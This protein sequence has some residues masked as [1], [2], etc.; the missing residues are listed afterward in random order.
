MG[1]DIRKND[2]GEY[3]IISSTSDEKI[4]DDEWVSEDEAKRILI[5]RRLANFIK[6]II[7]IDMEFPNGYY[8]NDKLETNHIDESFDKWY[9]NSLMCDNHIEQMSEKATEIRDRLDLDFDII[10][11]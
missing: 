11:R 8:I 10:E 7:E 4:H 5:R 1:L 6:E 3:K 2:K 9:L